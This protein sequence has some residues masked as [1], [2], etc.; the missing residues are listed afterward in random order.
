[1]P[2]IRGVERRSPVFFKLVNKV[3]DAL[4]AAFFEGAAYPEEA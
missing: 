4:V 1:L 3:L 2:Y